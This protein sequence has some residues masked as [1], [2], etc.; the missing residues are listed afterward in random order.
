MMGL[1]DMMDMTVI[2]SIN[3][4]TVIMSINDMI[5]HTNIMDDGYET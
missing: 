4:M 2:T 5:R 3:D 1:T